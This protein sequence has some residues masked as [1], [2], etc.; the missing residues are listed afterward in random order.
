MRIMCKLT[1]PPYQGP[2]TEWRKMK[3]APAREVGQ[4][5][6]N[7]EQKRGQSRRLE[8]PEEGSRVYCR[9]E[10]PRWR[11]NRVS[12]IETYH[13]RRTWNDRGRMKG[14]N[15]AQVKH[16]RWASTRHSSR[17]GTKLYISLSPHL[18]TPLLAYIVE[19]AGRSHHHL[20][21]KRFRVF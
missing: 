14:N 12:V 20:G 16:C 17:P 13:G 8:S 19:V 4:G 5:T 15:W 10:N 11:E 18:C 7:K 6:G 2:R 9:Y 3:K 21:G 1:R